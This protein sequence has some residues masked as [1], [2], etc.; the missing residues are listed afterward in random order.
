MIIESINSEDREALINIALETGLFGRD[1]AEFLLG[2][3]IDALVGGSL[4]ETHYGLVGRDESSG[5]A[6]GWSYFAPDNYADG[7]WNV[8]WIGVS[9]AHYGSGAAQVLLAHIEKIIVQSAGRVI[10]IETS[11]QPLL[12][13]ARRF[14][15]KCGYKECGRIPDFYGS[16]DA[17]IIFARSVFPHTAL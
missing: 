4:P 15:A 10:V 3:T 5:A 1:E 9:P 7:V 6:L 13:R 14:Y 2:G 17:K 12:E 16:G 11:D 8:W